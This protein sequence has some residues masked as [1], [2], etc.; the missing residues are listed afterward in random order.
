MNERIRQI[1]KQFGMSQDSFAVSIGVSGAAVSKIE[2]GVN[3]PSEQT[4]KLI[5]QTYHVNYL[6]LTEGRGD[7]LERETPA[8]M[9]ERLMAGESP[10]AISIMKAFAELPDAEWARLRDLINRIKETGRP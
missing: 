6:W 8:E 4:I 2:S 10:L 7:M 1:R 9:V 5:C 3:S